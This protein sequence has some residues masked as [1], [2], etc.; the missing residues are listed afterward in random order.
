VAVWGGKH[1]LTASTCA[2]ALGLLASAECVYAQES[3]DAADADTDS[4]VDL[5]PSHVTGFLELLGTYTDNFFYQR[6]ASSQQDATGFVVHP[7][8]KVATDTRHLGLS[9][10]FWASYGAFD[11]PGS[12]DD[13]IDGG[14]SVGL[15]ARSTVRTRFNLKGG[16]QY[17]HDPFGFE[18]TEGSA[19]HTTDIDK[20]RQYSVGGHYMFGAP[21]AV[22][23]AEVGASG[24]RKEYTTN[25]AS[26]SFLDS[27]TRVFDYALFYRMSPKTSALVDFSRVDVQFD[28]SNTAGADTREGVLYK[29][30]VGA[31]WLATAKTS[32]DIRVGYRYRLFDNTPRILEGVDWEAGV[33]WSPVALTQF[34]LQTGRSEQDSYLRDN[35]S[36]LD[37]ESVGLGWDQQWTAR[38]KSKLFGEYAHADFFGGSRTDRLYKYGLGGHYLV[39]HNVWLVGNA[40][41]TNRESTDRERPFDRFTAT[42]GLRIGQ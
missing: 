39:W 8:I 24:R 16:L 25:E 23:N 22:L 14:A 34:R 36:T 31:R 1:F 40:G 38:F 33:S 4:E 3:P 37:I 35:T 30:R 11:V 19:F 15:I 10:D 5:S 6:S 13:Y 28:E 42:L 18:R 21:G 9:A 17:G 32:G 26:T 20:W 7:E 27:K 2:A 29:A 41:F 12:A